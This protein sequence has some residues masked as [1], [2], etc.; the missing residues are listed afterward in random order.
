MLLV[1][2]CSGIEQFLVI[3]QRLSMRLR[4]RR[5]SMKHHFMYAV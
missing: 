5:A 4:V 1:E 2:Y 3:V